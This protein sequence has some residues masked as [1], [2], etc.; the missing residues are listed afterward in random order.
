[1]QNVSQVDLA[2]LGLVGGGEAKTRGVSHPSPFIADPHITGHPGSAPSASPFRPGSDGRDGLLSEFQSVF[3]EL[4]N[5]G[6]GLPDVAP[7]DTDV[8]TDALVL[9]ETVFLTLQS[10]EVDIDGLLGG[11]VELSGQA[12][13]LLSDL[14]DRLS[15][16]KPGDLDGG[17]ALRDVMEMMK[18]ITTSSPGTFGTLGEK[19]TA[20]MSQTDRSV[21]GWVAPSIARPLSPPNMTNTNLQDAD[22]A[23]GKFQAA[24][25]IPDDAADMPLPMTNRRSQTTTGSDMVPPGPQIAEPLQM[26]RREDVRMQAL[27]GLQNASQTEAHKPS[28]NPTQISGQTSAMAATQTAEQMNQPPVQS[29]LSSMA[30]DIDQMR[31]SVNADLEE[32]RISASSDRSGDFPRDGI[33][34]RTP[35]QATLP[36]FPLLTNTAAPQNTDA[37]VTGQPVL[38]SS[39]DAGA[40]EM[41]TDLS[42]R[43]G[44]N[45]GPLGTLGTPTP[46]TPSQ[47]SP[48]QAQQVTRQIAFAI[49]N[50]PGRSVEITLNPAELGHVRISLSS[51]ETGMVVSIQADRPETLELMRRHA[52]LLA[53]DF[54]DIGYDG[55]SFSFEQSGGQGTSRDNDTPH[56]KSDTT[57]DGRPQHLTTDLS[58][59]APPPTI[60]R[61]G[62]GGIDIRL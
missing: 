6:E 34:T 33:S 56:P 5:T 7:Q 43:E 52:D 14:A 51:A 18:D 24:T 49:Q 45:A 30:R 62:E 60:L 3:E 12:K 9:L 31:K 59:T 36:G 38:G 41:G 15:T 29:P 2:L 16:A 8:P 10:E 58:D 55:T 40:I 20:L 1:M 35:A 39:A 21:P 19:L 44:R 50:T 32:V 54:R 27:P 37:S 4:S 17:L 47:M 48:A 11:N 26:G 13:A 22:L 53:S 46:L 28:P 25:P 42:P 61:V 57:T 23:P